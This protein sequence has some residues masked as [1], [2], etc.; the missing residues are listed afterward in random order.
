MAIPEPPM[1]RLKRYDAELNLVAWA[2]LLLVA[3]FAIGR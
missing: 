2:T 3:L 1:K